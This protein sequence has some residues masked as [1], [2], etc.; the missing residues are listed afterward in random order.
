MIP[1]ADPS[2]HMRMPAIGAFAILTDALPRAPKVFKTIDT[3][4]IW[5]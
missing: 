1:R 2:S 3:E 4:I 5:T